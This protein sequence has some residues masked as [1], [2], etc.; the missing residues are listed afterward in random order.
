MTNDNL[1]ELVTQA[2]AGWSDEQKTKI[3]ID[4]NQALFEVATGLHTIE[5]LTELL[6]ETNPHDL[7]AVVRLI[8]SIRDEEGPLGELGL[9]ALESEAVTDF[10]QASISEA[11]QMKALIEA[12]IE[13]GATPEEIYELLT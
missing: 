5:A 7:G 13:K 2:I 4:L 8:Q 6:L 10:V 3:I 1:H 11:F 9:E 12:L